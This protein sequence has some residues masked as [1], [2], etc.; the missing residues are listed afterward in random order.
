MSATQTE[1]PPVLGLPLAGTL[2]TLDEFDAVKEY[3]ENY[4]YELVNGVLVVASL[5][6]ANE[7]DPNEELGRALRNYQEL[8]RRGGVLDLTLP[9]QYVRTPTS[10]RIADR[11]I[12]TGLGRVP[13]LRRDVPSIAVEF[14]SAGRRNRLRDYVAKRQEYLEV[15]IQE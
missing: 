7:T 9:Q 2:M 13:H 12:W 14:V 10:R 11:L 15:G 8:H 1:A 5:P 4:H 3:D 6:Y